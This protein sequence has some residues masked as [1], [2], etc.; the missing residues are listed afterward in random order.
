MGRGGRS[1]AD[2]EEDSTNVDGG[3]LGDP[4]LLFRREDRE[5][6]RYSEFD[7]RGVP[8]SVDGV[9]VSKNARKKFEKRYA[10]ALRK[11]EHRKTLGA[12]AS[13]SASSP[14][15]AASQIRTAAANSSTAASAAAELE[16]GSEITDRAEAFAALRTATVVVGLH[17]DQATEPA[18]DLALRC[19]HS[20]AVVP[21]CV[22]SADFRSR[23][24]DGKPVTNY[25]QLVRY[26]RAKSDKIK[27]ATLDFEGQNTVLYAFGARDGGQ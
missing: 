2:S 12:A 18:V 14:A 24:L 17:P 10:T 4:A 9:P 22:Y 13:G 7:G 3:L 27:T 19:G 6:G 26:L 23:R 20:F 5:L 1:D 25:E 15:T 16:P 21:C 8:T 11:W